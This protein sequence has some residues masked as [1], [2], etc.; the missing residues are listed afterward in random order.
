MQQ[1][2]SFMSGQRL[3]TEINNHYTG[4]FVRMKDICGLETGREG[5][6]RGQGSVHNYNI[7]SLL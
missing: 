6:R 5:R 7:I 1:V 2:I 4:F 3:F